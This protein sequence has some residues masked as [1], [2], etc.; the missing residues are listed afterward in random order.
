MRAA[1]VHGVVTSSAAER[2]PLKRADVVLRPTTPGLSAFGVT[3]DEMGRFDFV[4]IQDGSYVLQV[5]RTGYVPST[6]VYQYGARMG[7]PFAVKGVLEDVSVR[8]SP[9]ATIS[10]KVRHGDGE[11]AAGFVVQAYREVYQRNHHTYGVAGRSIS[12]DRGEYRLHGLPPGRYYVAAVATVFGGQNDVREQPVRDAYGQLV[13]P[14]QTVT[15]FLPSS[16]KLSEATQLTLRHGQ[17]IGTADIFLSRSKTAVIKGRILSGKSGQP[18]D[19][20]TAMLLREDPTGTGYLPYPATPRMLQKGEFE[21]RG[22]VPGPYVIEARAADKDGLL[23]ARETVLVGNSAEVNVNVVLR[24]DIELRG[25][26]AP[27]S[28][29]EKLPEGLKIVAEPRNSGATRTTGVSS[30]GTF[31]LRLTAGET[32]DLL[33]Q[34]PPN[35]TYLQSARLNQA[36]VLSTGLRLESAGVAT[37]SLVVDERGGLVRGETQPGVNVILLPQEGPLLRYSESQ[38]NE[39]GLFAFGAVAPGDYRVIVWF[40]DPPCDLWSPTAQFECLPYGQPVHVNE[41]GSYTVSLQP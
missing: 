23:F 14:E 21:I 29:G 6:T 3:T 26:V 33:L 4:D 16:W 25:V 30:D 5:S 22:V 7:L 41:G 31:T 17:D 15:T 8:L 2:K 37:L 24:G 39:W 20:A 10:G 19:G 1:E 11:P 18:G 27:A 38:A 12:D 36:D 35:D 13:P 9:A 32:Y 40:D 34:D 28:T